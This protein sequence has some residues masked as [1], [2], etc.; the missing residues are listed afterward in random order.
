M[1]KLAISCNKPFACNAENLKIRLAFPPSTRPNQQITAVGN[2]RLSDQI[3]IR[4]ARLSDA[5]PLNGYIRQTYAS[6]NHLITRATEFRAGSWKQRFW[7]ARKQ[8]NPFEVCLVATSEGDIVG[9]LDSWTDRRKRVRHTTGF[10]MSVAENWRGRGIGKKLLLHFIDWV[11]IH[12]VLERIELHVHSDNK[13]AIALY[14]AVGFEQEGVR[15]DAV[16]YE[17]G[18]IVD[19]HIMALWPGR[20]NRPEIPRG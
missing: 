17:D 1:P 8:T 3:T 7:I 10:A 2:T 15:K 12:E 9:M 4:E 19:D 6:A 13:A 20:S 11:Q 5:G 18:R 16:R 14:Q